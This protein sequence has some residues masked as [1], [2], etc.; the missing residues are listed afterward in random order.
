MVRRVEEELLAR[1]LAQQG[2]PDRDRLRR[3]GGP[4]GEDQQHAAPRDRVSPRRG[5]RSLAGSSIATTLDSLAALGAVRA[6]AAPR[7]SILGGRRTSFRLRSPGMGVPWRSSSPWASRC[8]RCSVS[9]REAGHRPPPLASRRDRPG[10]HPARGSTYLILGE[11]HLP[12]AA[13]LDETRYP[14][15]ELTAFFNDV[16]DAKRGSRD[17]R[18]DARGHPI[19]PPGPR[20]GPTRNGRPCRDPLKGGQRRVA[21]ERFGSVRSGSRRGLSASGR[22]CLSPCTTAHSA[23]GAISR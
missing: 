19:P 4:A 9:R 2:R 20:G 5:A 18:D 1:G 12:L 8:R 7:R 6:A 13:S 22:L 11:E 23:F 10:D 14:P 17:R 21:P 16:H 15:E 3:A